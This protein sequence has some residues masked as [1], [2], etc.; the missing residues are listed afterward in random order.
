M[1]EVMKGDDLAPNQ[2]HEFTQ[3]PPLIREKDGQFYLR[4][5]T[6]ERVIDAPIGEW[7][8]MQFMEKVVMKK[9]YHDTT[10]EGGKS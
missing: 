10:I 9:L 7:F 5:V 4:V 3:N 8:V 6:A 2:V 1:V